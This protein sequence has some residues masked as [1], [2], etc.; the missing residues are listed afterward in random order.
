MILER[1]KRMEIC[2]GGK[3]ARKVN[4]YADLER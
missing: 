3:V 1:L 4:K 2:M